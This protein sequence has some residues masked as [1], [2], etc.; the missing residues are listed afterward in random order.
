MSKEKFN[1]T[2]ASAKQLR[3]NLGLNQHEFWSRI[4]VTQSGGSRYESGRKI[5][6]PT[7]MLLTITYGTY[8]QA[9]TLVKQLREV[10]DAPPIP[11]K[12]GT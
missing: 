1:P 4:G 12:E 6:K 7:A 2:G 11:N 3:D 5:P 10:I 9:N 8:A